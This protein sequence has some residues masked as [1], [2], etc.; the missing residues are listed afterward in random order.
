[1]SSLGNSEVSF[2]ILNHAIL[3]D[4]FLHLLFRSHLLKNDGQC[5]GQCYRDSGTV[6]RHTTTSVSPTRPSLQRLQS[7]TH[8]QSHNA[9][10]L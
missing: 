10:R 1:M 7:T 4:D 9:R 6:S 8:F 2:K 5:Y 3:V